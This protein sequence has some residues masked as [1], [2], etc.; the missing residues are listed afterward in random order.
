MLETM[1]CT[2]LRALHSRLVALALLLCAFTAAPA[3]SAAPGA[4]QTAAAKSVAEGEL[5][6][7]VE[8]HARFSRTRHFLKTA[9]GRLELQFERAADAK[10]LRA[11]SRVRVGGTQ[12]GPMMLL[13][14]TDSAATTV[15]SPAPLT[16]TFGEKA[17]AVLLV[18]FVD[19]RSQ[20][21]TL[22]QAND[23]VFNQVSN[24]LKENSF[25]Q[26]WLRGSSFGWLPLA[27]AKTCDGS[28]IDSAG[29]QAAAA[30]GIDLSGY[31]R[32]V[33]VFPSNAACGWAGMANLGGTLPLVWINGWLTLENVGHEMGHTFGLRHAHSLECGASAVGSACTTWEYGDTID[34]MGNTA[35]GHFSAFA[36]ER[37]GWLNYQTQPTITT[38]QASGRYAIEAYSATPGG[39]PKALKIPRG[40]DPTTGATL[41]YFVEYRQPIGFDS[42]L[43]AW[44][45]ANFLRGLVVRSASGTD[46]DSGA[47]LDMTPNSSTGDDWADAALPF[48]QAYSDASGGVMI[49][50]VSANGSSA[51]VDVTL[52]A[53]ASCSRAAPALAL[54]ASAV[55]AAPGG[56]LTYTATLTNKDGSGC[57]A[58]VF[59]LSP[60]VPSG[61]STTLG[62]SAISI[63][64]GATSTTSWTVS[65]PT[66]ATAGNYGVALSA[67]NA[68]ATL[69]SAGA[70]ATYT[71]AA[72]TSTLS[73]S[74]STDKA[75]YRPG[76]TVSA[77][78]RVTS[79]S[80]TVA[81]ASVN[82]V[83]TRADGSTVTKKV[84]TDAAGNATTSYKISRRDPSGSWRVTDSAGYAGVTSAA[85]S[86][87]FVVQ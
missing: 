59:N 31:G 81:G 8:D 78:A 19:D 61:W 74:V 84:T 7:V 51:Q 18:N 23:V 41:W 54:T 47:Q 62:A 11:G 43:A 64:A 71:V 10:A 4:T 13:S 68:A 30:A 49:V 3:L 56:T 35:A 12:S 65:S 85:A 16:N 1:R 32:V 57:G 36:K 66:S 82:L 63:A 73:T 86:A 40:T 28:A 69:Y 33:Y 20:P 48:G 15:T 45:N 52:S 38:V 53:V 26:T 87:A 58:S 25:Q 5:E 14:T 75:S 21:Y 24:F 67:T 77:T 39:L 2:P 60:T 34:I 6:I 83:F 9:Q 72:T 42:S 55:S 76:D 44:T 80:S 37:L 17:A 27:I 70:N 46:T 79:G 29:R 50:A 22:A